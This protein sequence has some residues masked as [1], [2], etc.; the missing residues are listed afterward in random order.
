[1]LFRS[2]VYGI[3]LLLTKENMALTFAATGAF[4]LAFQRRWKLG[5]SVM[6]VS[7]AWFFTAIKFIIPYLGKNSYAYWSYT[8]LGD[9]PVSAAKQILT[10]PIRS[11]SIWFE[12]PKGK[13]LAKTFASW[14][15][16]PLLSPLII[17]ALPSIAERF[18]SNNSNYWGIGFQ[19]S[20]VLSTV[21]VFA[22]ADTIYRIGKI[23]K[24]KEDRKST[25]LNSSH[26]PLSRMPS[27]A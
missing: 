10:R 3:L 26:I 25:R 20:L 6:A 19:Y 9:E 5:I 11:F 1:M 15:F 18:W 13:T 27:S 16:L 21:L 24:N 14:A 2:W 12:P 4:A 23:I 8:A 7:V 22:T 17:I